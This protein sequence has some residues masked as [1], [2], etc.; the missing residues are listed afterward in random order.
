M[1]QRSPTY[2]FP[3]RNANELADTLRELEIDETWIHEIVRRKILHDQAAFTS[4]PFEEPE[5][6]QAGA[7]RRRAGVSSAT[8]YDVDTHFTPRYRPWRQRIAFVPD[9][10]LFQAHRRGQ[11]VGGHRRDRAFTETGIRLKSGEQLDGRHHRHR[12][13]LQPE[14]AGRHRLRGRR[15]AARLRRHASP[16]AGMMFTGVPNMVWVFGYFRASWTLRADLIGDFV[17]RCSTTWTRTG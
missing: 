10:D 13:R 15:R 6:V 9:G 4:V 5:A 17:P 1:L 11:G 12:D 8:E 16:T 14:R 3:G 7:A 2:F